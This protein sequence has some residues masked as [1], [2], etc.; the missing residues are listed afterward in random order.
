MVPA[1]INRRVPRG[2][3]GR[4]TCP[5]IEDSYYNDK[6]VMVESG[7]SN[8]AFDSTIGRMDN[9]GVKIAIGNFGS[10]GKNPVLTDPGRSR[11]P[12]YCRYRK[13]DGRERCIFWQ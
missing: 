9:P 11:I 1:A 12:D 6:M 4:R 3:G 5:K 2:A 10:T 13:Q 8:L 7:R